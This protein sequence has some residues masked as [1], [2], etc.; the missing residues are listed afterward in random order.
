MLSNNCIT[1][2]KT[3]ERLLP[4]C[5]KSL[6]KRYGV[7]ATESTSLEFYFKLCTKHYH[8]VQVLFQVSKWVSWCNLF[9][10]QSTL[11]LLR[12]MQFAVFFMISTKM[13]IPL[14]LCWQC[15]KLQKKMALKKCLTHKH[16]EPWNEVQTPEDCLCQDFFIS[17]IS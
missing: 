2:L 9:M 13:D 10:L 14:L 12:F 4:N 8:L 1:T 7:I 6:Q 11:Q 16:Q 17:F 5:K 3:V 15:M